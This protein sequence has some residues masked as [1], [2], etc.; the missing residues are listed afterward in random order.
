LENKYAIKYLLQVFPSFRYC[1]NDGFWGFK[2][3]LFFP[4]KIY[5]DSDAAKTFLQKCVNG[6][7]FPK[8]LADEDRNCI[9]EGV[10]NN[11]STEGRNISYRNLD[12]EFKDLQ[13]GAFI[14]PHIWNCYGYHK[15][16]V[17][18]WITLFLLV[19][20]TISFF[21]LGYLNG[22]TNDRADAIYP[23]S[24]IPVLTP[25][26]QTLQP[27]SFHKLIWHHVVTRLWYSFLYTSSIFFLF[28]MKIDGL[29]FKKWGIIYIIIIYT[30]GILC[31]AYT[32]NFVLQK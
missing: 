19:F 9:Y 6:R 2:R 15:E 3:E 23:I 16:W 20:T 7:V 10:L 28:S 11:F 17:F 30:A 26:E 27:F 22:S 5:V 29:N 12:I 13:N 25:L 21:I 8:L 14:L 24:N 18:Y 1:S 31:L 32:A 4:G